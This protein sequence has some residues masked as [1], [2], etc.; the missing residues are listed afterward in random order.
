ML[1]R[2]ILAAALALAACAP[3]PDARVEAAETLYAD[4][5]DAAGAKD[6]IESGLVSQYAGAD[7][8]AWRQRYA[9]QREALKAA[10]ARI[11][12]G[13]LSPL[14]RRALGAMRAGIEYRD[15]LSLAPT[16]DCA[17]RTDAAGDALRSS[18]Y[19]CFSSI[20][21]AI[22]FE[23]KTDPRT[24]ALQMLERLD[25]PA[26]RRALFFAMAPLWQ[27]V[28]GDGGLQSP[29]RRLINE[30]A[31]RAQLTIRL[32]EA[33]LGIAPGEGERWL[34]RALDAWPR[35]ARVE[36]WDFRHGYAA[37]VRAVAQ[38]APVEKLKATNDRFFADLGADLA[39]LGVMQ[40][41]GNRPGMSPVDYSD[42]VR[43]GREVSSAYRPAI[44]RVSV[45]LQEGGLGG[46][47]E[48][49]HELGHAVHFAAIRTRPSLAFTDDLT[50]AGEAFADITAWSVYTPAWQRKYLGCASTEAEG[51]R[52]RLGGVALDM[53]WGLFEIRMS[54]D[55]A[56]DPNAVWTDITQRYLGVAAHPELSW[57]AVR[58]QLVDDPG[59]MIH[60][61]LGAF[62]TADIRAR[63][64]ADIGA[65]DAGNP[66]WYGY[67]SDRLFRFGGERPPAELLQSFLGRPVSP[68]ALIADLRR[69]AD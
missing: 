20:G 39:A 16:G 58:G 26:R 19:A 66:R 17:K 24:A 59:Y 48:L 18:L 2:A 22:A 38:C 30:R 51:L 36:P 46:S 44:A 52:A 5:L 28:N 62:A 56:L 63:I 49:A 12:E 21:D 40:D 31:A 15:T 10:I 14:N 13:K 27:A 41:V 61:A 37:G 33:S 35:D 1:K 7:G 45:I 8:P 60:Y 6:T 57:W 3:A 67:V 43:V 42:F 29:Y 53:A 55:P 4:Y 65:F 69:A 64:A 34:E 47:A 23:G 25:E 50:L 54:R 9:M 32:A 68:D 11:D